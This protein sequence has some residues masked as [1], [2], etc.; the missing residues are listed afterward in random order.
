VKQCGE[1]GLNWEAGEASFGNGLAT[2]DK[3]AIARAV[4]TTTRQ[5]REGDVTNR[6]FPNE[7]YKPG[8]PRP[9]STESPTL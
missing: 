3:L 7:R 2:T 8:K 1:S 5:R 9:S 4:G 6:G